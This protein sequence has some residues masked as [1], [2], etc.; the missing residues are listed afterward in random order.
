MAKLKIRDGR[1][2][3]SEH[4]LVDDITTL[5]RSSA[6][7]IQVKDSEA[8]RQHCKIEKDG[9]SFKLID[10]GSR[11]GTKL[12]G[13]K[14]TTQT[15]K[16]G[17]K[18]VIGK[19]AMTFDAPMTVSADELGATVEVDTVDEK[20]VS[21][22]A[23]AAA[24]G[25]P[26]YLVE[27][28]EGVQKGETFDIGTETITMGR[29]PSNTVVLKDES[30][31]AY[32]AEISKEPIGYVVVDLG[33][34][35]GTF[36]NGEKIVKTPLSS[37]KSMKIGQTVMVFKNVGAPAED[38]IFGTV[39]LDTDMLEQELAA[40]ERAAGPASL[41]KPALGV[42]GLLLGVG[43]VI[44]LVMIIGA[45]MGGDTGIPGNRLRNYSFSGG[46]IDADGSPEQWRYLS[47]QPFRWEVDST[48][49][50]VPDR[51]E[52]GALVLHRGGGGAGVA[53]QVSCEYLEE[54]PVSPSKSYEL[55]AS[56]RSESAPMGVY[57]LKLTWLG[58]R[59]TGQNHYVQVAGGRSEWTRIKRLFTPPTWAARCKVACFSKGNQG[60][61]F[62]DDVALI[63]K[64]GAKE[65][66]QF[67]QAF[68][69]IDAEFD[70]RGIGFVKSFDRDAASDVKLVVVGQ[71]RSSVTDLELAQ[72]V[73]VQSTQT[74]AKF[75]GEIYEFYT[76][77]FV[78]YALNVTPGRDGLELRYD[79]SSEGSVSLKSVALRM[80]VET[81]YGAAEPAVYDEQGR[82][83]AKVTGRIR[84]ASEILFE[85]PGSDDRP[86]KFALYLP[87]KAEAVTITPRGDRKEIEIVFARD[88]K[89]SNVDTSFLVEMNFSGRFERL[90]VEK[91]LK[92][93][94]TAVQDQDY[95][96]AYKTIAEAK[97][98]F[99]EKFPDEVN[100]AKAIEK[101]LDDLASAALAT[102]NTKLNLL[103]MARNVE[104]RRTAG[105]GLTRSLEEQKR[106]WAGTRHAVEFTKIEVKQKDLAKSRHEE[107]NERE[108]KKL[109][110]KGDSWFDQKQ[111]A[112]ALSYYKA[113]LSRYPGTQFAK[114]IRESK[115]IERC[116]QYIKLQAEEKKLVSE[117][118][119][120]IRNLEINKM[121][122]AA[123]ARLMRDDA[124]VRFPENA[125]LKEKV[126]ELRA[127]IDAGN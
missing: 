79:L 29:H 118:L 54:L 3:E 94:E 10:L 87:S 110:D 100:K 126:K 57:G 50:C 48:V 42:L 15:L 111:Y 2:E 82:Q 88:L 127:K 105:A 14:V 40:S 36:V 92:D 30:A 81:G 84:G 78:N 86:S 37:G 104:A 4:E 96:K 53:E 85:V 68:D 95:T 120:S 93:L 101:Q 52:K 77:Q 27:F 35:N 46:K 23:A 90:G 25:G 102:A 51:E 22:S 13:T 59:R 89:L 60:K 12:N 66:V 73:S 17:D 5:G 74:S 1:G 125:L 41:L 109:K 8:S 67:R 106:I 115:I 107:E 24:S 117:A 47:R 122:Q 20:D 91:V 43:L 31:S 65:Q 9:G 108:A 11:N 58:G 113:V 119:K 56:V 28:T 112:L 99:G 6:N 63:T 55:S 76:T 116:Q 49:D 64:E 124:Y 44:G 7:I 38:E 69:K 103:K 80:T 61:V 19:F 34:T 75:S 21:P 26:R 121:W 45:L 72:S 33:S 123:L 16:P 18:V 114:T 83:M 71:G 39:V 32:H 98:E 62:F 97:A 70:G